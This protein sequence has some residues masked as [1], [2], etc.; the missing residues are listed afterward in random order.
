MDGIYSSMVSSDGIFGGGNQSVGF[1]TGLS[2]DE[3][4][5]YTT[6]PEIVQ[7][8]QN[9]L[10][11]DN[12][13]LYSSLWIPA[14]KSIYEANGVL[15]GLAGSGHI[16]SALRMELT[17]EAKFVRAFSNFYL[18]G[19]FGGIPLLVTSDYKT[20]ALSFR[21]KKD[22]VY[23]SILADLRDAQN[24][25][26]TDYSASNGERVRPNSWTAT[27]LLSR[28][29]LYQGDWVDAEAQATILLNAT[30]QFNLVPDLNQVFLANS[31]EA[32]WQLKPNIAGQNT[33]E[34]NFYI[35]TAPP[36]FTA[37]SPQL[38]NAFE[39]D[40]GRRQNWIADTVFGTDT[41]YYPFKYKVRYSETLTEY[42][43]VFRLAEIYLIRA[44]ARAYLNNF[45]GAAADLD[46]I[47]LRAGLANTTASDLSTLLVA[48]QH[49]RQ[50][51]LFTE[52]GHRWLDLI[53]TGQATPLL[54]GIKPDWQPNDTLF[55]IPQADI[56]SDPNLTQNPGY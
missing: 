23:Q 41:F 13:T 52:W 35:L 14:Y 2:S 42:S 1:L 18:T 43:M 19:L 51:E 25:L 55:P 33:N 53:R 3:L 50:V 37:L 47:R 12:T 29:Y 4:L 24:L 32:I 36:S 15:D 54:S 45:P 49:E 17:G 11:K 7:F 22:S 46:S 5:N 40:D 34:G 38:V 20:N 8:Y 9:A 28:I 30:S 39:P 21:S 27:A 56:S 26:P 48:I 6:L 16:S 31:P 44:E 10:T